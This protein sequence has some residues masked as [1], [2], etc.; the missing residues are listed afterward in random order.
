MKPTIIKEL[1]THEG[2]LV[3]KWEPKV[4][5]TPL[6][7]A[8]SKK[9]LELMQAVTDRTQGGTATK[10]A[11]PSYLVAGKTGTGQIPVNGSY[12]HSDYNASFVGIYPASKPEL[13]ILV[14]IERPQGRFRMG[15]SVAAPTF[16]AVAEEIG[17][18][19]GLP[20]DKPTSESQR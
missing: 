4:L 9:M 12:N 11:L 3:K 10:A 20:A 8:V 18:Y 1:R 17:H 2:E 6:S 19:L 5:G 14:T 13:A 16:A 7:P 15:G